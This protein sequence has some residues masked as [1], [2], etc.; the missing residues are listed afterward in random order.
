MK[1]SGR[2]VSIGILIVIVCHQFYQYVSLTHEYGERLVLDFV[3]KVDHPHLKGSSLNDGEQDESL[4]EIISCD[5]TPCQGFFAY[6]NPNTDV[7]NA[8]KEF[9]HA[10]ETY[11]YGFMGDKVADGK[12]EEIFIPTTATKDINNVEEC[13]REWREASKN[14]WTNR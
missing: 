6:S 12:Q 7:Q 10:Y 8:S 2:H 4:S 9:H 3:T 13:V 14:M 1:L 5:S 11:K